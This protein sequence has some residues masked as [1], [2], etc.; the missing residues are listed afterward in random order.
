VKGAV[1]KMEAE[2]SVDGETAAKMTM[3][4]KLSPKDKE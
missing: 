3:L 2:A 4:F 1:G